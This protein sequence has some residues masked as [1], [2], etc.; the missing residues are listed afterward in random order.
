M[1]FRSRSIRAKVV[2]LLLVPLVSLISLWTYTTAV[3]VHQVWSL[4][5]LSAQY[6]WF[7]TPADDLSRA[8]QDERRAA[9]AFAAAPLGRGDLVTLHRA[10]QATD[11]AAGVFTA[12]AK[13]RHKL[14]GLSS[15]QFD[16]LSGVLQEIEYI[17]S[18][19]AQVEQHTLDWSQVYLDY[20]GAQSPFFTLRLALSTMPVG[21]LTRQTGDLIEL[22]RAR[23]YISEEDALMAGARAA[24]SFSQAQ[25]QQFLTA[26]AGEQLL[27]QVHEAQLPADEAQ[28]FEQFTGGTEYI[29]L[30][31][32]ENRVS[33]LGQT[34]SVRDISA[35]S[36]QTTLNTTLQD[37]SAIDVQAAA[38]AGAEARSYA[39]GVISQQGIVGAVGLLAV[40]L[41]L[42]VSVRVGRSL[43]RELVGLR[44]SA[45]DL[46]GQRLPQ[47]M[48]RLR[49][50]E[51]VD[52]ATEVPQVEAGD[53]RGRDEI[54]QVGRAFNAVQRAAVEA[55]VEQA[56]LRRGIAAVFV[57]LARRSQ[58][59]LSRQ[60]TLLDEMERR[61]EQPDELADLFRLDHL[62]TRMRRHAEG[63]IILSGA[64]PGRS[65]R[66]PVRV[67]DVVRAAV[68]EVEDYA[69][70][71]VHRMPP[72]AV[73]G[74]AVSDVVHLIAELVENATVFSPPRTQVRIQ[75]EEVANGFV[76]EIDDRGLGMGEEALAAANERLSSS[77]DFDLGDT[78]RLGLFVVSRLSGRHGIRVSLRRSPYGGTTAVVLLPRELLTAAVAR[79]SDVRVE[80]TSEHVL[81]A[82]RMR[83]GRELPQSAPQLTAHSGSGGPRP[84]PVEDDGTGG[85]PR[86]RALTSRADGYL[87][88][89]E[90]APAS[91]ASAAPTPAPAA[92]PSVVSE[93]LPRRIRQASLAPQLRE[94]AERRRA[95]DPAPDAPP[96]RERSP[97]EVRATFSSYQ[98]GVSR[99]RGA[100]VPPPEPPE[101]SRPSQQPRSSQPS[102]S[103][104]PSQ[105]GTAPAEGPVR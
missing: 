85:L 28:L 47:V 103:S 86:R 9:V 94:A 7:G 54:A 31:N 66:R 41:S 35:V 6:T 53:T 81:P 95:G 17:Q 96:A 37:L 19:R 80:E 34:A 22:V 68:G 55:A 33:D 5:Q 21:N 60:L 3:S 101:P 78:D 30:T 73:V 63:L 50:G 49:E 14:H 105:T 4:T 88:A 65:W 89:R 98:R 84:A 13:D 93:L 27:Y 59:L 61:A 104:E 71:R 79:S 38:L 102:E 42:L 97:E 70:V 62:T 2:A 20:T 99:G 45:F 43:V 51:R 1:R 82:A 83:L 39:L 56:E 15:A 25:F 10:E 26:A 52:L 77:G 92:A 46:A 36:W 67:L 8:V 44:D 40:L 100:A 48:R 87:A 58:A 74:G 18:G 76:L 75:G 57:N 24:G 69:R 32:L 16:A 11:Q 23:E 72:V 91:A 64:A 90:K 12:H 29:A